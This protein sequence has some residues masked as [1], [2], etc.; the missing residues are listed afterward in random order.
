MPKVLLEEQARKLIIDKLE[1]GSRPRI[2]LQA[3]QNV[4]A[5]TVDGFLGLSEASHVSLPPDDMNDLEEIQWVLYPPYT[6][7]VALYIPIPGLSSSPPLI[8]SKYRETFA[9]LLVAGT[10]LKRLQGQEQ[11]MFERRRGVPYKL[12]KPVEGNDDEAVIKENLPLSSG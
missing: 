5:R 2:L 8:S 12:G 10:Q 1:P 6:R 9:N 3:D 7:S 11:L 4:M